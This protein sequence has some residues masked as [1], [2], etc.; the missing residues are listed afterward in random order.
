MPVF[1]A[2]PWITYEP[3]SESTNLASDM[4]QDVD[5]DAPQISTLREEETPPPQPTRTSKF[6]VKLLVNDT[7]GRASPSLTSRTSVP[8]QGEDEGEEDDEDE[9][10]QLIDDD[11]NV[12]ANLPI[13]MPKHLDEGSKR[14]VSHKRK[15]KKTEKKAA[16]DEKKGKGTALQTGS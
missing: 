11:D 15:P 14:K 16:E 10:D 2:S 5:M 4:N 12:H 13:P 6:R 9:E 3:L 1:R 7:S 8:G